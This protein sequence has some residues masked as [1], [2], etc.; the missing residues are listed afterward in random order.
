M[1]LFLRGF[2]G[3][4]WSADKEDAEEDMEDRIDMEDWLE[5]L[6]CSISDKAD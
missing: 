6:S 1:D 2:L 5:C 3:L 4:G